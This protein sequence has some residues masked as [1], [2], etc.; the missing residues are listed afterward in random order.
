MKKTL[1]AISAALALASAGAVAQS[2][3]NAG[4]SAASGATVGGVAVGT[5]VAGA[6]AAG[7]LA[8]I[9]SNSSGVTLPV[10]PPPPQPGCN[11]S[12]PLVGDVCVGTT[13]T[14][15]VTLTGTGTATGTTTAT[16]TT[17]FTYA[18]TLR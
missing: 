5:I 13:V 1:V 6:V 8:A 18:P 17:T 4:G 16:A 3:D 2:S 15:T 7:V 10:V 11:G 14:N 9:V 12:D